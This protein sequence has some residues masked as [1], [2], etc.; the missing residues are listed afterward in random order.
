MQDAISVKP[1]RFLRAGGIALTLGLSILTGA[2][3]SIP[4][5]VNPFAWFGDD[6]KE[7]PPA[8]AGKE[9][10]PKLGSVPKRPPSLEARQ[11]QIAEGLAADN[12]NAKYADD[13]IAREVARRAAAPQTSSAPTTVPAPRPVPPA[14]DVSRAVP[15]AATPRSVPP[16]TTPPSVPPAPAPTP[17]P[18]QPT[19]VPPTP[20]TPPPPPQTTASAAS[21]VTPPEVPQ[22]RRPTTPT[23]V[24]PQPPAPAQPVMPP[25]STIK[26]G[27]IYFGEGSTGLQRADKAIL[28]QIAEA[29]R[30]T[31]SVVRVVGYASGRAQT[32][33]ASRRHLINYRVSLDRAYAVAAALR[34]MGVPAGKLQVE[35]KGD[36]APIY[37]ETTPT[38]EA[39]NRRTEVYFVN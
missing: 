16:A 36:T 18:R 32:R 11:T 8:Q 4:D 3:E 34:E 17:V 6:E 28:R 22:L 15:Q 9:D 5:A 31:G 10:Y 38:G 24:Q 14:P 20:R 7:A 19:A 12:E 2:C 26:V 30:Q 33:D 13:K 21:T 37:A 39:A 23:M 27:T 29:Q 35:G 1:F 25:G